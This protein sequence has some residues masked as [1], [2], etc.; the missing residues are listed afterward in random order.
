MTTPTAPDRRIWIDGRLVPWAEA[1]VHVLSHS[2]QRGSL[3]FDYM[4]V[5][6]TPRG[7]AVF[8]LDD[9]VRRLLASVEMVGLPLRQDV[10]AIRAGDPRGG[11]REP[12]ARRR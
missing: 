12:R 4:G 6:E 3:V 9:H 8:R 7:P 1:T 5:H 2:H 10:A 11:A